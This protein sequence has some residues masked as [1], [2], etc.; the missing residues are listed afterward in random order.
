[1]LT[2]PRHLIPPLVCL[3]MWWIYI[4]ALVAVALAKQKPVTVSLDAK[5]SSTPLLLEASEYI[6]GESNEKFWE[7]VD[8]V[9][10]LT[11][12]QVQS[13]T[14]QSNYHLIQ[15]YAGKV[16]SSLHVRLMKFSLSLRSFSPAIENFQEMS[17]E[18]TVPEDCH[19]YVSINGEKTCD[20]SKIDDVI[21]VAA[22]KPKSSIYKFDHIYPR[23]GNK[24]IVA[25]LYGELGKPGFTELHEKLKSLSK[26]KEVTY[27]LRHFVK[28]PSD[29][30]TRLSGYGVELAI[31]S[32]EYKAKDDTKIEGDGAS[33]EEDDKLDDEIQGFDFAKLKELYPDQRDELKK[34]RSHLIAS[35][36]ELAALKVWELQDLSYQ[37]AQKVLSAD[38]DEQ[39]RVLQDLSQNFPSRT[40]SLV[41]VGVKSDV[42]NEMNQNKKIFESSLSLGAGESAMFLNGI[43]V[44]MEVYD[45]Y[46]LLDLMKS[47]ARLM[48]G[49]FSMGFKGTELEK[50]MRLDLGGDSK[51]FALDIRHT[52][53]Q[54]LNDLESDKKY[55]NW[56]NSIQDILRPTFPGMLRHVAKNFFHLVYFVDP[57]KQ[58]DIELIKM[59]EAFLVH[60]APIRLSIVFIVNFDL[61]ADP[62]EDVGIAI[63]RAFDYIRQENDF[64][65]ALSFVTDVYEKTKGE[66][67]TAKVVLKEFKKK[68]SDAD[69][70]EVFGKDYDD[71]NILRRAAKDYVEKSGLGDFPQVLLNGVPLKKSYLTEDTFEE[72]VVSQIMAQT[73]DIQKAV[74]QGNL[75]D[76]MNILEYLMEKEHIL[77]RMNSRVLSPPKKSLDFSTV[78]DDSL[79]LDSIYQKSSGEITAIMARDMKYLTR[80]DEDSLHPVT[81]WV[82]CDVE[83]PQGREL[84]YS[85][86]RQLKHSYEMRLGIIFNH[87]SVLSSDLFISK[88]VY[89][90]LNTLENNHAKSLVTKLIKEENVADLK[91]GVKKLEDLEVHGMDMNG[92]M[93]ALEKQTTDFLNHHASFIRTVL[94]WGEGDRG[95]IANGKVCGPLDENERFMT[96]DVD[97]LSKVEYQNVARGIKTQMMMMG[98]NGN[99]GSDLV[100]KISSLLSS[101]TA[102]TERKEI[103]GLKDQHS[104][105]KLP[106]S[107]DSP[108]YQIEVVLDP[109]SQEAQ[110]IAP[111]I[112]VLRDVV[113][114]DVKIYMNCRDKISEL[115]VK[116]YYRYV[117]EPDLDFK[118]DGSLTTGPVAK[119]TD[120]PQKSILTLGVNPPESWL[121]ESVKA[122]HDLD[123]LLMEEVESGVNA[124]FAL[125]YILM[126]GHCSDITSGQP[127]RGLQ[128]TLGTNISKPLVDTIVMANLGYFQ[129]KANPG[130]WFLNLREGRSRDIYNIAGHE[131]TDTPEGSDDVVVSMNSFKS[132]IIRV[133]VEKKKDKMMEQLLKDE[134]DDKSIWDSISSSFKPKEETE[135]K[136]L[137]I[138]S[139]ASGHMY[140]RLMRIMM[141]SVLKHTESKVKFWFLKNYLSPSFKDFIPK[142]AKEYGFEY[143]LVQYK[144]PRWL[145]QQKEKQRVMWGY[146]ILFLDV[147]FPLGVKKFIFV[148]ADQVVRTDL[149]EL[150]DLDLQGA[151]Y[152]YTPFCSS[153]KEMDGF[154]FWKSGYWASHLAG[155]EYH[156]SA[157]Y[158]VDLKKF[159]RIAAGD[160]LRGQYQGLSQDPNSL[161]NLD[162]DLPNNMI[163][164][165]SIKSLPQDWLWCETWCSDE[166]KKTAKTIDLCNNPLTKEPKLKAALRIL[167]E[168]KEYDYEVKVLWDKVYKTN[169]RIQVEYEPPNID[170]AKIGSKLHLHDEL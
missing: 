66:E 43:P 4:W 25:V 109:V 110:K 74:Y 11:P 106:A 122:A 167:P 105:I 77:P 34:L 156:I 45:I 17:R 44:E 97:L 36:S 157:L 18:E 135:E 59:A 75:H 64:P 139:L 153:R 91:S 9:S 10:A 96:E 88:A 12:E 2:P 102:S 93:K 26:Q 90:A 20:V 57:A 143:E 61:E 127:P 136:I 165:V 85:A 118:P 24:N 169:T 87:D 120:L 154:R 72:G 53:I 81:V 147:L 89:T 164:Q 30:K 38:R 84:L 29:K 94:G 39:I 107:P 155:R 19:M 162:Q 125:E 80:K 117:L 170:E 78:I 86:I 60:S 47:E 46:T 168:W 21:K 130:V 73:P 52:A 76:Y 49:L 140:E 152:G 129:L 124:E 40:R 48:E 126:E 92:Y 16:L 13:G 15:K 98:I 69:V 159:R 104:A 6:A 54:F 123:N 1:M 50:F 111:M 144:W 103:T 7:F 149:Q 131:L 113:N 138:F 142:M 35:S 141:L 114:V 23:A 160:R 116:N 121:V 58:T 67:I 82:V 63:S 51:E 70:N 100:M 32:T 134:D 115:P 128:F 137:N 95:L 5:W 112:K 163:H 37:T 33:T 31:K 62:L 133:K 161:S 99:R 79:S 42:R 71:Y 65:K 145:N 3:E 101:K 55:Q 27:L 83:T 28:N 150:N 41:K 22:N 68:Y 151:P 146:K 158:V 119:F 56:P 166:S 14:S 8:A 108:A 132:K 148:D